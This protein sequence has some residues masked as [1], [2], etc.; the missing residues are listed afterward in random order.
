[1]ITIILF[2]LVMTTIVWLLGKKL[3]FDICPICAGVSLVWIGLLV[4]MVL[5]KLSV[6]NYQLPTAILAGG[7]V[8]GIMSKLEKYIKIKFILIWKTIFVSIGFLV[9]YSLIANNWLISA[10]GV[11]LMVVVTFLLKETQKKE[12]LEESKEQKEIQEKMKNCC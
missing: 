5:G 7:T 8:V 6:Y 10:C 12:K 2:I 4:G 3:P 1:M 9:I 11:V